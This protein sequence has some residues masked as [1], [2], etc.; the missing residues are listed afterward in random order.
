MRTLRRLP[1]LPLDPPA[2]DDRAE[3]LAAEIVA[4]L[5]SGGWSPT[6]RFVIAPFRADDAFDEIFELPNDA[7]GKRPQDRLA[8][9]LGMLWQHEGAPCEDITVAVCVREIRAIMK[10]AVESM[11]NKLAQ[12]EIEDMQKDAD[13]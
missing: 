2:A 10:T 4:D 7:G 9:A 3:T 6:H 1:D 11:A 8:V 5:K 12:R 13:V